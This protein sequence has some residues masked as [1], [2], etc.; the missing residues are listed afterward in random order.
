MK[1]LTP[2]DR[3]LFGLLLILTSALGWLFSYTLASTLASYP[4]LA[5]TVAMVW[6]GPLGWVACKFGGEAS[7]VSTKKTPTL[8]PLHKPL[9]PH[10]RPLPPRHTITPL[11][12]VLPLIVPEALTHHPPRRVPNAHPRGRPSRPTARHHLPAL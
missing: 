11:P 6:A 9:L 7:K 3:A 10:T 1:P 2:T 8:P 12:D 5:I 4:S